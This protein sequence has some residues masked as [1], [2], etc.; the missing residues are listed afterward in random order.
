MGF[1]TRPKI[2]LHLLIDNPVFDIQDN[3][4]TKIGLHFKFPAL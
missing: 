4:N 2:T 3:V 1:L